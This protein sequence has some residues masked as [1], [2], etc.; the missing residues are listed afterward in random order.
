MNPGYKREIRSQRIRT[1]IFG[2]VFTI[3]ILF[4]FTYYYLKNINGMELAYMAFPV[5]CGLP[6]IGLF[7]VTSHLLYAVNAG[8]TRWS[9]IFREAFRTNPLYNHDDKF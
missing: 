2:Y 1:I 4:C 9:K 8:E 7:A 3:V 5:F 6:A